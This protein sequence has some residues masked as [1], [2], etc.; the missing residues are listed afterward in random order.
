MRLK[1]ILTIILSIVIG[2]VYGCKCGGP[3]TIKESFKYTDLIIYG[4]VLSKKVVRYEESIKLDKI[5]DIKE[6]LDTLKLKYFESSNIYKI[7]MEVIKNYKGE[8]LKDTITIF[9]SMFSASCG[10]NFQNDKTYIIYAS[11]KCDL[12]VF[13]LPESERNK[14]VE[15]KD[16]YWTNI[17]TRTTEFNKLEDEELTSIEMSN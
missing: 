8:N 10:Y 16:T 1:L 14:G 17:C 13:F 15:K 5:K 7:E 9:T 2:Y 11:K 6:K 4:K 12:S 3:G